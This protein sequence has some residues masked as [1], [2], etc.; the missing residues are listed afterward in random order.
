MLTI[1]DLR[2]FGADVD[3]GLGR[4]LNNEAFYL[5]LVGKAA[6]DANYDKLR[7]AIEAKDAAAGFEAA[8]ALKGILANLALTPILTPV[9]ELTELLR[10]DEEGDREGLLREALAQRDKLAGLIG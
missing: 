2:E 7:A 8:H 3:E 9:L 1:N 4:C 5:R 6:A 10:R